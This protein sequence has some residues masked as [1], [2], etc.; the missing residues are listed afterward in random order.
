MVRV[1]R[2]KT[3]SKPDLTNQT[4]IM[5]LEPPRHRP[6]V[7]LLVVESRVEK[8][9]FFKFLFYFLYHYLYSELLIPLLMLGSV[10]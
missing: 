2:G 8:K 9:L 5:V 7:I 6:W 4:L 3:F 1:E 10:M